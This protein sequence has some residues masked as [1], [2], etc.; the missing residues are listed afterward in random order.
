MKGSFPGNPTK[1]VL[2][3]WAAVQAFLLS[4]GEVK[5]LGPSSKPGAVVEAVNLT[6]GAMDAR[7]WCLTH[8]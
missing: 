7:R 6:S 5:L 2:H 1:R 3:C 8:I 4:G